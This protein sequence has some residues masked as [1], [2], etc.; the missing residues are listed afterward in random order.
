MVYSLEEVAIWVV[1]GSRDSKSEARCFPLTLTP[2]SQRK[3][4]F[5][6]VFGGGG[7]KEKHEEYPIIKDK[8]QVIAI[9]AY[10]D[11][12]K[13]GNSSLSPLKEMTGTTEMV[14]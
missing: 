7:I 11:D 6:L 8:A 3:Y 1:G 5:K 14:G 13:E 10:L 12:V 2:F 9:L 4:S